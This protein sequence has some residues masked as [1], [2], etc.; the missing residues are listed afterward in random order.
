MIVYY[1]L[2]FAFIWPYMVNIMLRTFK[3]LKFLKVLSVNIETIEQFY[4]YN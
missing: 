2:K 4:M 3:S 1:T